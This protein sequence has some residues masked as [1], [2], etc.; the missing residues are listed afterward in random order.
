MAKEHNSKWYAAGLAFQCQQSGNCCSGEPGHV[1]VTKKE[2]ANIAEYLGIEGEWL[3]KK[4]LRRVGF[5]YSLTEH[6]D[7][8][9]VFLERSKDGCASCRIHKVKPTQ[10]RT[11]PFWSSNLKSPEHWNEAAQGCPG[12][13]RGPTH[14][15]V[16]IDEIRLMKAPS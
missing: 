11:W 13:N 16:Q 7:G 9:C 15:L 2:I 14:T 5:R 3:P 8:D 1:W 4:Y 12:I 10:C 6:A